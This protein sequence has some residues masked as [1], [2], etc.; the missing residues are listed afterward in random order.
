MPG[1]MI[2]N[3][4]SSLSIVYDHGLVKRGIPVL[5]LLHHEA[6]RWKCG[7]WRTYASVRHTLW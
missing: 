2:T 7:N 1:A 4:W 3:S 6:G 5:Y